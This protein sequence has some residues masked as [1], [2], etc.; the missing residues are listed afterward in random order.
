MRHRPQAARGFEWLEPVSRPP[1]P[2]LG[3]TVQFAMMR[4]AQRHGEFIA[5]FLPVAG[6]GDHRHIGSAE[7]RYKFVDPET[8]LADFWNEVEAWRR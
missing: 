7:T 5:D 8:L 1:I 6:K 4:A 2:F 3:G